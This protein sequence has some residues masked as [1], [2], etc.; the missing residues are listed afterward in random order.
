MKVKYIGSDERIKQVIKQTIVSINLDPINKNP[1]F[2]K[3]LTKTI[4]WLTHISKKECLNK[5][6]KSI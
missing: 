4:D 1:I 5:Y 6:D 2:F 3:I